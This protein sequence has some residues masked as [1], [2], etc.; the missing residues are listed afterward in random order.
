MAAD[1]T[2]SHP[3]CNL[4]GRLYPSGR[5]CDEAHA[6][7]LQAGTRA[8]GAAAYCAP[9]RCYCG[10]CPWWKPGP[11]RKA[12]RPRLPELLAIPEDAVP[13]TESE[14]MVAARREL[15]EMVDRDVAPARARAMRER[16]HRR[17]R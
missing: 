6:P 8:P 5:W 7:Y 9:G 14:A 1:P 2:C 11:V 3:G 16:N 12:D 4:P 15:A 10:G 17:A 13:V